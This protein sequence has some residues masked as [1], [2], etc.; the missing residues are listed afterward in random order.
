MVTIDSYRLIKDWF[1]RAVENQGLFIGFGVPPEIAADT[2]VV[3]GTTNLNHLQPK[4]VIM[5]V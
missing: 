2:C 1:K 4:V 5:I 3:F